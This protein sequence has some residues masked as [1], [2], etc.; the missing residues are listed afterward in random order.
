MSDIGVVL[1]MLCQVAD[2]AADDDPDLWRR[3]LPTLLAGLRPDG[4]PL[5]GSPLPDDA[6]RTASA[7]YQTG[8]I[9]RSRSL[10]S[11]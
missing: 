5:Q 2:V 9:R 11:S 7:D 3:Y 10:E 6:F 1:M 4:P 8:R